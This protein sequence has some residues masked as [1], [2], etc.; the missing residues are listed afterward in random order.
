MGPNPPKEN[1]TMKR[2][3]VVGQAKRGSTMKSMRL[4]N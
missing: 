1:K 4:A 2:K 3:K